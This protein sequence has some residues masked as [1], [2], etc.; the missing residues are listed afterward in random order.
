MIVEVHPAA[1]R[2]WQLLTERVLTEADPRRRANLEVVARHVREEV[3]GDIPA[4]MRT[5]VAEPHYEVWGASESVGPK[6]RAEVRAFYEAAV[7]SGKNRLEFQISRVTVDDDTVVTEGVFRH[8]YTGA[9]LVRR[10]F[11]SLTKVDVASWYL[12]EYQALIVWPIDSDGLIEGEQMYAGEKP[13]I[14]RRLHPGECGH[15][16]PRGRQAKA[17]APR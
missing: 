16:G 15:L 17:S 9:T 6:G 14:L 4:L 3:R 5:L 10:G 12:V 13:R 11:A 8:A 2:S 1:E 7:E